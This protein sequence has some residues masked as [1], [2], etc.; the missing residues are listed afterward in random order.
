MATEHRIQTAR[1][2]GTGRQVFEEVSV[3]LVSSNADVLPTPK[4]IF[5]IALAAGALAD[6][7]VIMQVGVRVIDAFL[8]L[9]G[10]GVATTTLT[11]KNLATAITDPMAASGA[12]KAL[13]RCATIDDAS[14]EIAAGG[15]LRVTSATGASQPAATVYVCC[16]R[17]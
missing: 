2:T 9:Q 11:V 6:T 13:V 5:R 17:T 3:A 10:A 8:I 7:D 4:L 12:D 15:T 1:S 14:Y 16:V